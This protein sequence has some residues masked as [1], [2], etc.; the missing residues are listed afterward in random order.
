M[1]IHIVGAAK[2][3]DLI[4]GWATESGR[5][6]LTGNGAGR[7][8]WYENVRADFYEQLLSE[9]KVPMRANPKRRKWKARTD[10]RNEALD[11]TVYALYL[12]RHLRLHLR[13]PGHWNIDEMRL[14]QG[15][16]LIEESPVPA[17]V[18]E[19]ASN[20]AP[21]QTSTTAEREAAQTLSQESADKQQDALPMP[22]LRNEVRKRARVSYQSGNANGGGSWL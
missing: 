22:P 20:E 2:A 15:A 9:I 6:R 16:L 11:C 18:Q 17:T 10:R 3:K 19:E 5:V 8:H 13:R 14:R 21:V 7:M 1:Q 12:S 4:L